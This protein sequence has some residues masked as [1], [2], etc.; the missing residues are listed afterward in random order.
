VREVIDDGVSGRVVTGFD[1]AVQALPQ[2]VG[3][4]R[5]GVR[6]RFE[7]RFSARRMAKD[8]LAIYQK[9][10]SLAGRHRRSK[11]EDARVNGDGLLADT[12]LHVD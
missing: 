11:R 2:V 10:M 5:R 8:Y 3:L 6:R 7:R 1:E 12:E 9:Q 4:D